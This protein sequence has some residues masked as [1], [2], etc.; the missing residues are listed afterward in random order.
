M[1]KRMILSIRR[2]IGGG[3]HERISAS[4][5]SRESRKPRLFSPGRIRSCLR[6]YAERDGDGRE[7]DEAQRHAP[8]SFE[9]VLF[10]GFAPWGCMRQ[11]TVETIF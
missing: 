8:K 6:E 4:R 7:Q 3:A 5:K 9:S 2:L 1:I 10:H 11:S